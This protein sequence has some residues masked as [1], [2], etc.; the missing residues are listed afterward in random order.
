MYRTI[1][2]LI[3]QR[4]RWL[5]RG[6]AEL[7]ED[8]DAVALAVVHGTVPD[9]GAAALDADAGARAAADVT[10]LQHQVAALSAD[11]RAQ[12]EG[13]TPPGEN[14]TKAHICR[15]SAPLVRLQPQGIGGIVAKRHKLQPQRW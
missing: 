9:R 1:R 12:M 5:T 3:Q 15:C 2:R 11:N 6:T 13:L 10:V 7:R 14:G 8:C 4:M